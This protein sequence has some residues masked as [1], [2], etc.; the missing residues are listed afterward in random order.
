MLQAKEDKRKE[1]EAWRQER[2]SSNPILIACIS[3]TTA[4]LAALV[5]KFISPN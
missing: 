3:L 4:I 1:E 2:M 5:N